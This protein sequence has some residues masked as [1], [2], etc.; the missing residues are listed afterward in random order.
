LNNEKKHVS[1]GG[2]LFIKKPK[3][4]GQK[5][6]GDQEGEQEEVRGA[7]KSHKEATFARNK[8]VEESRN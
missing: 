5:P 2:K 1:F 3:Q 7:K 4:K 6:G 8:P